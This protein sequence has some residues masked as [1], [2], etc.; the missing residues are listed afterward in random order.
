MRG[1]ISAAGYVPHWRLQR[2][3]IGTFHGGRGA[4]GARA[5]ASYDEDST[6]LAVEAARPALADAGP[7]AVPAVLL[8]ASASPTYLEKTNATVIHAA[9]QLPASTAA[10]DAG[11]AVRSGIGSLRAALDSTLT[12]LVAA[13]ELRTGMPNGADETAG[14]DAGAALVVGDGDAVI[15]EYLG[16]ASATREFLDRWRTP[17]ELR[18]KQW[19]EK[20][21]ENNY[22]ALSGAAWADALASAGLSAED[23]TAAIVVGPHSRAVGAVRKRLGLPASVEV[24]KEIGSAGAA[25]AAL[26]LAAQLDVADPGDVIALVALSD[27]ADV[28]LFRATDAISAHRPSRPVQAQIDAGDDSLPYAKY[29]AWRAV[30]APE[31]PRRPEPARVSASAAGRS[32][33]WKYGF[34]GSRDRSSGAV[35]LP[36]A[37]VSFDGG[38]VDDMERIPMADVLGTVVTLTVDRLA[39][40]PSPPVIFAVVDFDGGGRLP[41]ELTDARPEQVA[42]GSRVEMTFRRLNSADGIANYFW[43]G[44]VV[45]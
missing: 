12:T 25:E 15:A 13:G 29:L 30:M 10:Y 5:V 6:T 39:Y 2:S 16:A 21:G 9:L 32:V 23:V 1:I 3:A 22:V 44:R 20:F 43:K 7:D 31:P 34:V 40:S 33:E 38:A 4:P 45:P 24:A 18:T 35:H 19:E 17:G 41:L 26:H 14:G 36:P 42:V 8:F 37:R 27:G 11:G 28:V